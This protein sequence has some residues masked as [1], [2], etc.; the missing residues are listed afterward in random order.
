MPTSSSASSTMDPNTMNSYNPNPS[1][2]SPS[3]STG[4]GAGNYFDLSNY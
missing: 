2:S 1:S 3:T 4:I